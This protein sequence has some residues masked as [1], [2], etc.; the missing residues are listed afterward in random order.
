MPRAT[1]PVRSHAAASSSDCGRGMRVN[2]L[3]LAHLERDRGNLPAAIAAL[4]KAR[5]LGAEDPTTLALLGAYLTEAGRAREAA[6]LLE[7]SARADEPDVEILTT[8][9]LALAKTGR[10]EE[11]L[12]ALAKA[13]EVS[14]K[15][16][17]VLV[18][19]GTVRLM[20]GDTRRGREAFEEALRV[21][22]NVARA[23]SSLGFLLAE[24]GQAEDAIAHWKSAVALDRG[25]REASRPGPA[26]RPARARGRGAPLSRAVP[27]VRASHRLRA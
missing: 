22:P 1:C 15:S 8:R 13:R 6:D 18:N 20:A 12:A 3:Y 7:A 5:A 26:P 10:F 14:P 19:E 9:S 11:A 4:E 17:M 27:R 23:H 25:V 21:N 16:A 24:G 2:H